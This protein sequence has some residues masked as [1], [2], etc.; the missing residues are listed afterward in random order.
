MLWVF[1][2]L[3]KARTGELIRRL[4]DL[5]SVAD[6]ADLNPLLHGADN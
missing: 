6:V 3:G 5:D 2:V 1:P 4:L